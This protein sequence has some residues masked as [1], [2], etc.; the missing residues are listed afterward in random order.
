MRRLA[1]TLSTTA[2]AAVVAGL[3]AF[4]LDSGSY[5]PSSVGLISIGV[6]ASTV[7]ADVGFLLVRAPWGRWGLVLVTTVSMVLGTFD[8]GVAGYLVL[9]LGGVSIVGLAGP[10][11]RFWVRQRPAADALPPV[12]VTLLAVAPIA[13]IVIGIAAYDT[14]SWMHWATAATIVVASF[15]YSRGLPGSIWLLRL[16]VPLGAA[17]S[18]LTMPWP[19]MAL[20]AISTIAIT[21]AAWLPEATS[22]T[23]I[24]APVLPAPYARRKDRADASD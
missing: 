12:V 14:A 7:V 9:A 8:S 16:L 5:S 20:A 24:P 3:V 2:S 1:L 18:L 21:L 4:T 13:P 22:A 19:T 11:L 23:S 17:G 10:W 15:L 6:L